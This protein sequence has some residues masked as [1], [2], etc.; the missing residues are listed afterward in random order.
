MPDYP[1]AAGRTGYAVGL[2]VPA[3]VCALLADLNAAGYTVAD[4]PGDSPALL[5]RLERGADEPALAL[6]DYEVLLAQLPATIADEI[7]SAWGTPD[8]DPDFRGGAF[9]FRKHSF[10]NFLKRRWS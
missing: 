9:H 5:Q 8:T 7:M 3:S 4:A 6:A 10:G 2:D 1:G